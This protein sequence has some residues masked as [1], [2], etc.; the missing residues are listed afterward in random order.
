MAVYKSAVQV[1]DASGRIVGAGMAYLH[2]RLGHDAEQRVTG[3][4]S[5]R[6]WAPASEPPAALALEDGR[7]LTIEVSREVLSECSSNH[8]LR[9]QASWPPASPSDSQPPSPIR[10]VDADPA[11]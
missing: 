10:S 8:I 9:Y 4:V 11:V 6:E 1:R 3:T 5:L 2:L 7:F